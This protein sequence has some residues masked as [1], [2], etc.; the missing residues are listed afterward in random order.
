MA[1]RYGSSSNAV[2]SGSSLGSSA[3]APIT[4]SRTGLF[5]SYRDTVI[6]SSKTKP[7]S[8][9]SDKGKGKA[10]AYDLQGDDGEEHEGLL[11]SEQ[12]GPPD[13]RHEV[14][15]MNQLPPQ[16]CVLFVLAKFLNLSDQQSLCLG[17]IDEADRVDEILD[18]LKP[19]CKLCLHYASFT[20]EHDC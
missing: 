11:S 18:R 2:A 3:Q 14:I 17:R 15:Q 16:W 7:R 5:L 6:R 8:S 20:A 13:G 19:K 1:Y 12:G 4:R 9:Y 10:R